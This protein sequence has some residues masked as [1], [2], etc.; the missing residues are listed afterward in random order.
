M[1]N[2]LST[3][4]SALAAAQAGLAT[5]AHNIANAKTPG[6]NRQVVLQA[7]VGGQDEGGGF[8]GKGT[9]VISV[10]RIY[11]EYLGAQIRVGQTTKGQLESH[12]AQINR[13]N[14]LLADPTSGL[15]P[16]LQDFFKSVQNL[17]A[18]PEARGSLLASAESMASRFQSMDGQLRELRVAVNT[19]I[20]TSIT[21]IN[22]YTRQIANLNE[23]IANAQSGSGQM[24]N[25]LMDQRDYMVGELSKLTKVTVSK[26]GN[27]YGIFIGNGQPMV[28]GSTVSELAAVTSP[29][30]IS[31][32][33][34]GLVTN[35]GTINLSENSLQGGKL[36]GLFD[37]R[38][39]SLTNA[40][41]SL[42]RIAIGLA[43][44]FNEQH[45][46]GKDATGAM[47]GDFFRM[48]PPATN[49]NILNTG[50][51]VLNASITDVNALKAS[52]YKLN[53]DGSN[54]SVTRLRDNV[55]VASVAGPGFP[56]AG[57]S[58]DGVNIAVA[59]GSMAS[60]DQFVIKPTVNAASSFNV[61]VT[62]S[63]NIG[64]AA[65]INTSS[66]TTNSGTGVISAGTVDKHFTTSMTATPTTLTFV[67]SVPPTIPVSGTLNDSAT[68]P[69]TGFGFEVKVTHNGVS[70][71]YPPNT[72]VPYAAGAT[73]TF[74]ASLA[75]PPADVGGISVQISGTPGDGDTFTVKNNLSMSGDNRNMVLLGKL[76]T[77]TALDGSSVTFQGA[78]AQLVSSVGNK[79]HELRVG[80]EAQSNLVDQ[81]R[82]AQESD[83][84]VNLD[85][86][87]ANLLQY[88]QAYVAAGKVMQAVK[89]MFDALISIGR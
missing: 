40:Q 4:N 7:A 89:E 23:A 85:E 20:S 2:I 56:A 21:A 77:A 55:S 41:N 58:V 72:P 70:T 32:V 49:A 13:I 42:G 9:E 18:N 88:Q 59:S 64:A 14:N 17:A 5:T 3:T 87:G 15:S 86:E 62:D 67:A 69:G 19:E 11:N 22:S 52:D 76:Q 26:D 51:A 82:L 31:E 57:I 74:G 46:L 53:F 79:T 36:G 47:A 60:G 33:T 34:V 25:D 80:S 10:R 35:A 29:T 75:G 81:L 68:S 30:D 65:P 37:F 54:Y 16:V 66:P 38:A 44:T 24:P 43:T 45:R 61:L 39:T 12:Y 28:V 50:N 71:I 6:Y 48:A 27:S 63:N 83:S 73:V 8:I 84:G 1:A 78:L